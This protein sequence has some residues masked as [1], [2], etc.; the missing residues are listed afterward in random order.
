MQNGK[1]EQPV[2]TRTANG[3][4]KK[5]AL[6]MLFRCGSLS[7][8]TPVSHLANEFDVRSDLLGQVSLAAAN[9]NLCCSWGY[10]RLQNSKD[11]LKAC[12]ENINICAYIQ[13]PETYIISNVVGASFKHLWKSVLSGSLKIIHWS[14][15]I[16]PKNPQ[17]PESILPFL[18]KSLKINSASTQF[19]LKCIFLS[20]G[21]NSHTKKLWTYTWEHD[22]M[23]T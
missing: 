11:S 4:N 7:I 23:F 10:E 17:L 9:N 14:P 3:A 21:L 20:V 8:T 15:R 18:R 13:I 12:F 6:Y 19:S 2:L 16:P 22:L 1:A 5:L